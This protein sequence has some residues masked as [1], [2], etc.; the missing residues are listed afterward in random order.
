MRT[1][2]WD[3]RSALTSDEREAIERQDREI[4]HLRRSLATV[5]AVRKPIVNRAL[6]RVKYSVGA[7]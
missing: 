7:R 3:W 1:P 4:E 2:K 6:N 5:N